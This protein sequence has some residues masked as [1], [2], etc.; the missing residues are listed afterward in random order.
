M[1]PVVHALL[2]AFLLTPVA[3]TT[4]SAGKDLTSAE[5]ERHKRDCRKA[6][7]TPGMYRDGTPGCHMGM[8]SQATHGFKS[9]KS[10]L[11][12]GQ[13]SGGKARSTALPMKAN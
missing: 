13:L 1:K 8:K 2:L 7:G 3:A 4:A 10:G 5:W 12:A 9:N 6:G 11:K